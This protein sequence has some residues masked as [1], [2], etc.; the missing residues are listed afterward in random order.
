MNDITPKIK[1]YITAMAGDSRDLVEL[2]DRDHF[3]PT[4]GCFYYPYWRSK[5]SDY[6]NARCQ[7]AVYT[8]ALLYMNDYPGVD[9]RGREEIKEL[10]VA[11]ALYWAS[12]QNSDGSFDEWYAGEHGFAAT[13][14][15]SFALSETFS[16]LREEL[17]SGEC[18]VLM[19]A[20][21]GSAEWLCQHD[22]LDKINH[23]AVGAGALYSLGETLGED[24]FRE[25][26][27]RKVKLVL[28]RQTRE[29]WFPELGGVD[30]GYSFLTLEY[31]S[32]CYLHSR[33]E[34]LKEAL[35]RALEFL[36]YFVHPDLTTGREYNLCGNSYISLLAG[37]IM[38]EFSPLARSLFSEG[39]ARGNA[40][41]QLAQDDLSRC[42]H[43]YNGLLAYDHYRENE[44]VWDQDRRELPFKSIPFRR[45]FPESGLA[46]V[47]TSRYYAVSAGKSGGLVKVFPEGGDL[48]FQDRG[49][50]LTAQDQKSRSSFRLGPDN[51][52]SWS[53]EGEMKV[54]ASFR[55]G[56]YFFPHPLARLLLKIVSR[57]P[58]GYLIVKKGI[59]LIRRRKN[60]SFQLSAVSGRASSRRLDRMISF[61]DESIQ[62]LDEISGEEGESSL[63]ALIEVEVKTNGLI[64]ARPGEGDED[65]LS[66][67]LSGSEGVKIE[68]EITP[69]SDR[70]DVVCSIS[71][72]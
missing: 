15:S 50:N 12:L 68:K 5:S 44:G 30:T 17:S 7:E 33:D 18:E 69:H 67:I 42:Y 43:L 72:T 47:K 60:A 4:Y 45:F 10:A 40:M 52:V 39:I 23:E 71:G 58:G 9:C 56:S 29:G 22:D 49:Y 6:V 63:R 48:S 21:A 34:R 54:S 64:S 14:F 16:L 26:A 57:L 65:R 61:K 19:K 8:L 20:L 53:D 36:S 66:E 59:D 3:S 31:L 46:A 51:T 41:V 28:D 55:E 35:G 62:I 13:A 27:E 2:A 38:G 70:V 32:H 1:D 11:G 25:K 37:A 24:R